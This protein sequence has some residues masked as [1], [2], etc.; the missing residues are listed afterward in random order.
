MIQV[1]QLLNCTTDIT[2][3]FL[4]LFLRFKQLIIKTEEQI[5]IYRDII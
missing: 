3:Y 1:R 4:D 5:L 2:S